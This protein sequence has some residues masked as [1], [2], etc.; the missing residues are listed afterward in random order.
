MQAREAQL[1]GPSTRLQCPRWVTPL[2]LKVPLRGG[3]PLPPGSL[4]GQNPAASEK[5]CLDLRD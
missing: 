2:T 1:P 3:S 5:G 4:Q